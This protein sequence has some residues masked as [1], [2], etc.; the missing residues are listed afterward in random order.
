[1]LPYPDNIPTTRNQLSLRP[2]VSFHVVIKFL[3]PPVTVVVWRE[4]VI[5]ASMPKAAIDHHHQPHTPEQNVCPSPPWAKQGHIDP[6]AKAAAVKFSSQRHLGCRVADPLTLEPSAD[7]LRPRFR[8][9]QLR[10]PAILPDQPAGMLR[11]CLFKT[12]PA[13]TN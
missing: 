1:M 7:G 4:P 9:I 13:S 12:M 8:C 2:A 10:H 11:L 6:V 3:S 5:G